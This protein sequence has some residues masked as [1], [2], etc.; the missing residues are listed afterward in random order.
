M[1]KLTILK[2]TLLLAALLLSII[3]VVNGIFIGIYT[4]TCAC[5]IA[6]DVIIMEVHK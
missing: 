3:A 5:G 1:K 6:Y 2:L 4:A